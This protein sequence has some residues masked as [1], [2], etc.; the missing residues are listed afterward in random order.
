MS[1]L[2]HQAEFESSK[3]A[4]RDAA[5]A[6]F[7]GRAAKIR[8]D[9]AAQDVNP[10]VRAA[11]DASLPNQIALR[12]ASTQNAAF[13]L[14][15]K[16]QV[17]SLTTNLDQYNKQAVDS[18]DPRLTEQLIAQA[19]AA[20]DGRVE[21]GALGADVAAKLKVDFGSNVYRTKIEIAMAKDMR[22]G[23]ALFEAT[24]DKLNG[25]DLKIMTNMATD[26]AKQVDADS[27]VSATMPTLGDDA[28]ARVHRAIVGQESGGQQVDAS[29]K[30]LT[31]PKG[32]LGAGQI[33][34][35]TFAQFAKPG[36]RIDNAEDN[37]RVS[38]R[39]T[40]H[41]MEKYGGDWQRAAVAYFSGEGNVAPAGS[42]TPWKTDSSDGRVKTSEYVKQVGDR[43]G[44]TAA[45]GGDQYA[46]TRVAQARYIQSI[47][48]DPNLDP[49]VKQR[50]IAV[51]NQRMGIENTI[52]MEQRKS[53]ADAGE[54][55]GIDLNTG[56][57]KPGTFQSIA[58][59]FTKTGDSSNAAV[60]QELADK[61]ASLIEDAKNPPDQRSTASM[62]LPG[63]GGRIAAQQHAI[64][65]AE[66]T[67]QRRLAAQYLADNKKALAEEEKIIDDSI[68]T[69]D[70]KALV[71]N[72]RN[73]MT[74]AHATGDKRKEAALLQ[75][76]D[77]MIE[78]A[79]MAKLPPAERERIRN[80]LVEQMNSGTGLTVRDATLAKWLEKNREDNR[81]RW[82]Q[83]LLAAAHN[84]G[85]QYGGVTLQD[86]NV[87]LMADPV[88]LGLWS[89]K[90]LSDLTTA[91]A[92]RDGSNASVLPANFFTQTEMSDLTQ[93]LSAMKPQE[94]KMFLAQLAHG[95]PPQ[96]IALIG[97]QMSKK[98]PVSDSNAAALGLFSRNKPGDAEIAGRVIDGMNIRTKGGEDGKTR[99]DVNAA[100]FTAIDQQ[101]G[102]SRSGMT[103]DAVRMQNNAIIS[104]YLALTANAPDRANIKPEELR[105][106]I[107][108]IV[109]KRASI[110]GADT[111]IP[112]ELE[113]Y[114]V[115]NGMQA[116]GPADV[117]SLRPANDGK[118]IT[119]ALI[120][121]QGQLVPY[122]DG[123][124]TVVIP[125][126]LK[127]GRVAQVIDNNTGKPWVIDINRLVA[128]GD[129]TN[130]ASR[131]TN[132]PVMPR[133][134]RGIPVIVPTEPIQ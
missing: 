19:N 52:V 65:T 96:A 82:D 128:R 101:L 68:G 8:D 125:D 87:N 78:G 98:D 111:L 83:D 35:G 113:P 94:Q 120:R 10:R 118:P 22:A 97:E 108:E 1:A 132:P 64:K 105:Q 109:G 129:T 104:N 76:F 61:E 119:D 30:I 21:G 131:S 34:P 57:Y 71:Q 14:W 17:G 37:L 40:D 133:S 90:R 81:Q 48:T 2:L 6:D 88:A 69:V 58:D 122:G 4:D 11:V 126:P 31:S 121:Q 15:A 12:R 16:A 33:T 29:G 39:I 86:F 54:K 89:G 115:K 80:E 42:P 20:I 112:R 93:R 5:T 100:L 55:A 38:K 28:N 75:K 127:S 24:K 60:Y 53:A 124:Y 91:T 50:R 56:K 114:Q 99:I 106:A 13:G 36:E 110:N 43:L 134:T 103:P 79:T 84:L 26:R 63:A 72:M 85:P 46:Q 62:L 116:I 45:P 25:A 117:T 59:Q 51:A 32:A 49:E 95:V 66:L 23:L 7:D 47:A 102:G 123:T 3:I 92:R 107:T 27:S 70:P 18:Q 130:P 73:A 9:F 74:L 41:Y 77:A 44:G 67:E